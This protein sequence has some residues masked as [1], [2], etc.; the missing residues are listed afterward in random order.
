MKSIDLTVNVPTQEPVN[1][2][3]EKEVS[4]TSNGTTII[5]PSQ[6]Y[7]A[8]GQVSATVAVPDPPTQTNRSVSLTKIG[9]TTI[10]PSSGY[11]T[12]NRV[13]VNSTTLYYTNY[14]YSIFFEDSDSTEQDSDDILVSSFTHNSSETV[15]QVYPGNQ[16][17]YINPNVYN[18]G[19][20]Y[21]FFYNPKSQLNPMAVQ[22]PANVDYYYTNWFKDY[23]SVNIQ[24]KRGDIIYD[25]NS[26]TRTQSG[27]IPSGNE[28]Y[29]R[30]LAIKYDLSYLKYEG[31][32]HHAITR[33]NMTYYDASTFVTIPGYRAIFWVYKSGTDFVINFKVNGGSADSGQTIAA[34]QCPGYYKV[35]PSVV[36]A[37]EKKLYIENYDKQ[38]IITLTDGST[39]D[40]V[41][42]YTHISQY[43][44]YMDLF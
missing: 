3:E 12:M 30:D 40:G 34:S 39:N 44:Y 10:N 35:L 4:I 22:L 23:D 26:L 31:S 43:F 36:S 42:V 41:S 8:I 14:P 13:V 38:P 16:L 9:S 21:N 37:I 11:T 20:T 6:G 27:R 24:N 17:L 29:I 18:Y 19:R 1:I 15:F 25:M 28:M 32:T 5:V 2:E 33:D 7:D